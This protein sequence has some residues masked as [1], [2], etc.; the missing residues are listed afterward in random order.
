MAWWEEE[1]ILKASASSHF[2]DSWTVPQ[3]QKGR[4]S[5]I[6]NSV[7]PLKSLLYVMFNHAVTTSFSAR[8]ETALYNRQVFWVWVKADGEIQIKITLIYIY[9]NLNSLKNV[10]FLKSVFSSKC[11]C[12]RYDSNLQI[13]ELLNEGR[14]PVLFCPFQK[15]SLTFY[16]KIIQQDRMDQLNVLRK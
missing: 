10:P 6:L 4:F 1:D 11:K 7:S 3:F 15:N 16:C 8:D 12:F 2:C 13:R 9:K 5:L 14:F